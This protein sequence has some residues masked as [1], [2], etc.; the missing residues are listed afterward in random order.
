M[1][2]LNPE[3]ED[4]EEKKAIEGTI[5][6]S[7]CSRKDSAHSVEKKDYKEFGQV[8]GVGAQ[9]SGIT[10]FKLP[11]MINFEMYAF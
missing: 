10:K 9:S 4:E 6:N 11:K 1:C 7:R 3:K 5:R 2:Y 8:Q